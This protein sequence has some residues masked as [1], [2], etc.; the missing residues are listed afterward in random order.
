MEEAA[1]PPAAA[2]VE[3][4]LLPVLLPAVAVV[5]RLPVLLQVVAVVCSV[6]RR[7]CPAPFG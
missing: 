3:V 4:V 5:V 6:G 1:I 7:S 2:V